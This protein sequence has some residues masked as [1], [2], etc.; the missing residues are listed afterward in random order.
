VKIIFVLLPLLFVTVLAQKNEADD[1]RAIIEKVRIYRLTKE[2][3]LTTEQAIQFFPRLK[4]LQKIDSGFRAQQKA[5]LDN[6]RVLVQEGAQD[7]EI[8]ES[9]KRYEV[10][11]RDRV[12]R[13]L[14]KM[15]EIRKLL[16]P[17][18]QARYLIFQ[19]DFE[20]EIR[21]MIKEVKKIRPR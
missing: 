14:G 10:I 20:R 16:T 13:Q 18:Q 17:S 12:E 19:D 4:E 15:K 9:L 3:D 8:T 1:P 2:L 21:Q 11:L 6:L 5:L 7:Q